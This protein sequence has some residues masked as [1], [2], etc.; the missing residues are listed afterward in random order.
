MFG[1]IKRIITGRRTDKSS[2]GDSGDVDNPVASFSAGFR[3][4]TGLLFNYFASVIDD[5]KVMRVKS[6]DLLQ[7][8]IQLGLKH[9]NND[10]ISDA[11]MRF[12]II[13]IFWPNHIKT[14]YYLVHCYIIK[15]NYVKAQKYLKI[16]LQMD[17]SYESK[18]AMMIKKI[19]DN[20][21]DDSI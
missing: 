5:I 6:R 15:G 1:K 14:Y 4:V 16:L 21:G 3:K 13:A 11:I 9:L 20:I 10:N 19:D 18:V 2:K 12:R 17:P 7:T 8:N